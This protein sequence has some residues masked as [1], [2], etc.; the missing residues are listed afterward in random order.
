MK[1]EI[2]NVHHYNCN[3]FEG[4]REA[5]LYENGMLVYLSEPEYEEEDEE[6]CVTS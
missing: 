6:Q 2:I 4:T 3:N 1:Y 5:K